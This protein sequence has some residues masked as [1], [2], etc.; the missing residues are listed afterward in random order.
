MAD[1]YIHYSR[2]SN[3]DF[4][5]HSDG[6][7]TVIVSL[8]IPTAYDGLYMVDGHAIGQSI[9]VSNNFSIIVHAIVYVNEGSLSV[10]SE[11]VKNLGGTGFTGAIT[12]SGSN[13]QLSV[14]AQANV[15]TLGKIEVCGVEQSINPA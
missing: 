1:G 7:A 12:V 3:I 6:T 4:T 11:E 15:Y 2:L 13:V 8:S 5:T 14:T 9:G 10:S